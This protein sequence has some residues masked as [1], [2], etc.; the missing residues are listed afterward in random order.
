MC[1][2]VFAIFGSLAC[3]FPPHQWHR[4]S[5]NGCFAT[6]SRPPFSPSSA[7]DEPQ[8]R[9]DH[10]WTS[11]SSGAQGFRHPCW[12]YRPSRCS[13]TTGR[14]APHRIYTLTLS[15]PLCPSSARRALHP[16]SFLFPNAIA[17]YRHCGEDLSIALRTR[18]TL[19]H[20]IYKQFLCGHVRYL[21]KLRRRATF[22]HRLRFIMCI[23]ISPRSYCSSNKEIYI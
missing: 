13:T 9:R 10:N 5:S 14:S 23:T 21:C 19:D 18:S 2:Y 22:W 16:K 11:R 4:R 20:R 6:F 8:Q 12:L 17:C 7:S 15:R 1:A 3:V